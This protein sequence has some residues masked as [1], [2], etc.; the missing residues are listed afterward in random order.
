MEPILGL[1]NGLVAA[2]LLFNLLIIVWIPREMERMMI[3]NGNPKFETDVTFW[4]ERE[5]GDNVVSSIQRTY[6]VRGLVGTDQE[7]AEL[8][9]DILRTEL[10]GWELTSFCT[11]AAG[12]G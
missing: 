4:V 6:T 10:P 11:Q 8:L 2:L 7:V 9:R 1:E 5:T 3:G 12:N